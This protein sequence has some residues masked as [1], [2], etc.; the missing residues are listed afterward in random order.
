[1]SV[2]PVIHG[3]SAQTKTFGTPKQ[4]RARLRRTA[5]GGDEV[6]TVGKGGMIQLR[7]EPLV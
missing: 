6:T 2:N 7:L 3:I 5:K 4:P 1:M